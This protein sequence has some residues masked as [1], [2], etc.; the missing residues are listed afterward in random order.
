MKKTGILIKVTIITLILILIVLAGN[1]NMLRFLGSDVPKLFREAMSH[2]SR[3]G[4]FAI[5]LPRLIAAFTA[6][7]FCVLVSTLMNWG[8]DKVSS[9]S[10]ERRVKTVTSILRSL[11]KWL[12][13]II[14]F[15]WIFT[16]FGFNTS[17]AFAGVGIIALVISF[18]AQS[19]VEDVV[20]GIFIMFEGSFNVGDVIVI[21]DF[22][23]VVRNIGVRTTSLEDTGG[24]VKVVNNSDIRNFQNR[25]VNYSRAI[26]DVS[27]AYSADI[28]KAESV[29]RKVSSKLY[30]DMGDIFV[31][32]PEY[33]GVQELGDSGVVL[34]IGATVEEPNIFNAQRILNREIKLAFDKNNIEIPFMQVV[35]H[36]SKN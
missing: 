34:R 22:R 32:E 20:T 13:T 33:M 8:I 35:V 12:V 5:S 9:R 19:L 3:G 17:A 23:G 28:P 27:I 1:T 36:K 31:N 14:G 26:C 29:I 25:S 15:I 7:L 11:V 4:T 30:S 10:K 18:G 6:A 21:D 2:L 16:I 24:N